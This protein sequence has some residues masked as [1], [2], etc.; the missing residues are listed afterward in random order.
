MINYTEQNLKRYKKE[1]VS[2]FI[3]ALSCGMIYAGKNWIHKH[4]FL[5][6]YELIYVKRGSVSFDVNG[7]KIIIEENSA[8]VLPPYKNISGSEQSPEGT[9][10]Y[11]IDFMTD[12]KSLF[13]VKTEYVISDISA[14]FTEALSSLDNCFKQDKSKDFVKD[15]YLIILLDQLSRMDDKNENANLLAIKASQYIEQ[16]IS[17]P[18]TVKDMAKSLNYNKDYLCRAVKSFY[19]IS[20]KDYICRQ[21]VMTAQKLLTTSEFTSAEIAL[22]TGFADANSFAKFFKYHVGMSPSQYRKQHI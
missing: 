19:G 4:V 15:S 6:N 17:N 3:T 18:I 2:S 16:N 13:S 10:F 20:L 5:Q 14:S 22:Q 1:K 7:N 11:W 9:V 12:N 21:K 8:A